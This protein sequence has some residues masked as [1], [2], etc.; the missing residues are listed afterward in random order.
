M[1]R[2]IGLVL[3]LVVALSG[4]PTQ[5]AVPTNLLEITQVNPG[6]IKSFGSVTVSANVNSREIESVEL[7]LSRSPVTDL[8]LIAQDVIALNQAVVRNNRV[9]I[10]K[11]SLP[12]LSN[13]VYQL[14]LRSISKSSVI[15]EQ[16]VPIVVGN[17]PTKRLGVFVPISVPPTSDEVAPLQTMLLVGEQRNVDWFIDAI[18][19]PKLNRTELNLTGRINGIAAANP[20]PN[21]TSRFRLNNL[22]EMAVADVVNLAPTEEVKAS[23]WPIKHPVDG[24]GMRTAI[25]A[26]LDY[27]VAARDSA[28]I[29]YQFRN[30]ELTELSI[31][32]TLIELLETATSP[33]M[34]RQYVWASAALTSA[35]AISSPIGWAP[36]LDLATAFFDSATNIPW[37]NQVSAAAITAPLDAKA[38]SNI[39]GKSPVFSIKHLRNLDQLNRYWRSLKATTAG[40]TNLELT[41]NAIEAT[42]SWWWRARPSGNAVARETKAALAAELNQLKISSRNKVVL[43]DA[44]GV[45]PITITNNRSTP[46]KIEVAGTGLGTA[47][48]R[49]DT[50]AIEIPANSKQVIELPIEVITPGSIFAQL[51]INGQNGEDTAIAPTAL[52]VEVSQYRAV[53][54]L[55]V[56]GAFGVLVLLS[57]ISIRGRLKKRREIEPKSAVKGE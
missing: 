7:W 18:T 37:V 14:V 23:V 46:A 56:Y 5:A 31:D 32:P 35:S 8:T 57:S 12:K 27:V 45:I 29:K 24:D 40:T 28:A 53:A 38:T 44:V 4:T 47:V 39:S 2:V 33:V 20:D 48:V 50:T 55:V 43:P 13:G 3:L 6:V 22:L 30:R 26:K 21:V 42:S 10:T 9:T 41:S 15:G 11:S 36:S 17:I 54:Q 34:V 16:A 25:A 19:W 52:T 49:I 1:R 51:V